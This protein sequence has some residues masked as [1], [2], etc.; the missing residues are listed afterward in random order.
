MIYCWGNRSP[1][2]DFACYY[3]GIGTGIL[4]AT[5]TDISLE[6][7]LNFSGGSPLK[8]VNSIDYPEPFIARVSLTLAAPDADGQFVT[9]FG[10]FSRNGTLLNRSLLDVG[11]NKTNVAKTF[12][13]RLRF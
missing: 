8:Q 4:P 10:L 9:E 11:I 13:W 7:P 1:I 3:F 12:L 5:V 6:H 2:E